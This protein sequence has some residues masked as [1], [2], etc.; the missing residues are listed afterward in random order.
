MENK[1]KIILGGVLVAA[2]LIAYNKSDK[3]VSIVTKDDISGKT[4]SVI[5]MLIGGYLIYKSNK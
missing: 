4:L 1:T 3:K 5:V 2:G